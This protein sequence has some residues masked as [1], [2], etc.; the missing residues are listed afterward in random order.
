MR[1]V[2]SAVFL[3]RV[4]KRPSMVRH[5][6]RRLFVFAATT[7]LVVCVGIA[8]FTFRTYILQR[9]SSRVDG[10]RNSVLPHHP[11]TLASTT[12]V[13]RELLVP[14]KA[15]PQYRPADYAYVM[16][17]DQ[18]R[19]VLREGPGIQVGDTVDQIVARIGPPLTDDVFYPKTRNRAPIRALAYYFAKRELTGGNIYDPCVEIFF[20]THGRVD[21]VASNV[22]GVPSVNWPP[23]GGHPAGAPDWT[24]TTQPASK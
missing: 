8:M 4:V 9:Q 2:F 23:G 14:D 10:H 13:G 20:D 11:T 24:P 22:P 5:L 19:R 15:P 6:S 21:S 16:P 17:E 12:Q 1:P 7:S 3:R 18:Q